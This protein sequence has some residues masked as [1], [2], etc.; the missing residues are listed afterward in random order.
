[1][2]QEGGFPEKEVQCSTAQEYAFPYASGQLNGTPE[3][4]STRPA[5]TVRRK[6]FTPGEQD[7]TPSPVVP[8][9][10]ASSA[11][12][13]LA[14]S[15]TLFYRAGRNMRWRFT[16][17]GVRLAGVIAVAT[18][19]AT[20]VGAAFAQQT[21]N[22]PAGGTP[23]ATEPLSL[24][25]GTGT[26]SGTYFPLGS[27][28]ANALSRPPGARPCDRGGNC[29]VDN[30]LAVAQ[31]TAGSVENVDR[32]QA[33]GLDAA[34]AQANVSYWA[35]TATG[36]YAGKPPADQLNL[37]A[38]LYT[39]KVHVVVRKDSALKRIADLK[40]KRVS[41]G[42]EGSGTLTDARSVL[43]A[44]GIS[45][46]NIIP[47][48][49][50]PARSGDLLVDGEID[51]LFVTGGD[52]MPVL[53]DLARAADIRFLPLAGKEQEAMVARQ[54]F[55]SRAEIP[56][57]A[58]AGVEEA[59]PTVGMGALLLIR[60]DEPEDLVFEIT[61]ALWNPSTLAVLSDPRRPT[62]I[63]LNPKDTLTTLAVPMHPGARR[64]YEEAGLL[65]GALPELAEPLDAPT[66]AAPIPAPAPRS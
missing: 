13:G 15:L 11:T 31:A 7:D 2:L 28:I 57:D 32:L 47:T 30:L 39:E 63:T 26:T 8:G 55:L 44:F 33:G 53:V 12:D 51:A 4:C 6:P 20:G 61:R 43:A 37:I 40:G 5:G 41:L 27:L 48:Y 60:K 50:R 46:K 35:R 52:P 29:G 16:D 3:R 58:Y 65:E 38:S 23:A 24:R 64:Y 59:T 25:I 21:D 36:P 17:R 22:T 45:E 18:A 42:P 49:E 66:G 1:L 56:S 10:L 9:G 62:P 19:L 14:G 34:L 54:P